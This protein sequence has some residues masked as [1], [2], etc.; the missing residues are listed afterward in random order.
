MDQVKT[1]YL[2][3]VRGALI[4]ALNE[5]GSEPSKPEKYWIDT[6]QEATVE[7]QVEEGESS[8]LRGGD[9][10][11]AQVEEDDTLTGV[12]IGFTNAKFDALATTIMAGGKLITETTGEED[13]KVTTITG[14][15]ADMMSETSSKTPFLIEIYVQNYTAGGMKDGFVKVTIPYCTG[16]IPNLSYSDQEWA[17]E[18]FTVKGKENATLNKPVSRKEFVASLPPEAK[19]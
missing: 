13:S 15:E 1:G 16:T 19:A 14:W 9:R 5:D 3:G 6:A 4:T 8:S 11:L 10:V 17:T 2:R 7:A 18:E 12:E